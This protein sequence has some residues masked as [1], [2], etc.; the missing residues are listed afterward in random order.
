MPDKLSTQQPRQK[1]LLIFAAVAGAFPD[2]D[3][4]TALIDPLSFIADWHRGPTHSILMI[5]VW[6]PLLAGISCFFTRNN[7]A[8]IPFS[9]VAVL[10]LLSHIFTD[11][12]TTWGTQILWPFSSYKA[13]LETSFV[14]DPI[15]TGLVLLSL[16]TAL[17][18][19]KKNLALIG[20]MLLVVYI[21]TQAAIKA[22]MEQY[23]ESYAISKQITNAQIISLPQPLA[24]F[25]WTLIIDDGKDYH[26][27]RAS[28]LQNASTDPLA[29]SA[30]FFNLL[31]SYYQPSDNL[32]W[33]VVHPFGQD[34]ATMKF[35]KNAW[36]QQEFSRFRRFARL[37]VLLN[38]ERQ[39]KETCAWFADQRFILP[40]GNPPI[41]LCYVLI[42]RRPLAT[43]ITTPLKTGREH[44]QKEQTSADI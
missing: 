40:T 30:S 21:G 18:W 31:L 4:I 32:Y 20:V 38:L 2:I 9:L 27:A 42:H 34:P 28:L 26:L 35:S 44:H 29:E 17:Y 33:Q 39:E 10:A 12:I 25:N 13:T 7:K 22:Q 36:Q 5:A 11:T 6:A 23:A 24:P 14:I 1:Q 43:E 19:N 15:M 37:P 16:L 41:C 3:Y 8:F